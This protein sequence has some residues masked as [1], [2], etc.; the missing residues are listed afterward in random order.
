MKKQ[1]GFL[2]ICMIALCSMA[3]TASSHPP[4]EKH[5]LKECHQV[6]ANEITLTNVV[7]IENQF[8]EDIY[9]LEVTA[10]KCAVQPVMI[11][12]EALTVDYKRNFEPVAYI[13]PGKIKTKYNSPWLFD[14]VKLC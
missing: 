1:M 5:V 7:A 14:P 2:S 12:Q 11:S 9:L 4:T 13:Q 3:F 10:S 8:N 6:S